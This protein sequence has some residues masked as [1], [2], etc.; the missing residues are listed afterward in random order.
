MPRYRNIGGSGKPD[1][2]MKHYII[3]KQKINPIPSH[4]V[5]DIEAYLSAPKLTC[6][7]CGND[8]HNLHIHLIRIHNMDA[9]E[10]NL[11]YGLPRTTVLA[12]Q[13][14]REKQSISHKTSALSRACLQE[15]NRHKR[16]IDSTQYTNTNCSKCNAEM[17]INLRALY[18]IKNRIRFCK[19]CIKERDR[20]KISKRNIPGSCNYCKEKFIIKHHQQLGRIKE[21]LPIYCSLECANNYQRSRKNENT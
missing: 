20:N 10:Y 21:N 16:S 13:S 12:S 19:D 4:T 8:Y 2:R 5:G 3:D 11:K 1:S 6:L 18:C 9:K 7:E 17:Q 14:L 15:V